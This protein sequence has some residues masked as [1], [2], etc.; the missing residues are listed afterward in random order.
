MLAS[1][2]LYCYTFISTRWS[3]IDEKL[4][5]Q[6]SSV[7]GRQRLNA[8]NN[9]INNIQL[10]LQSIRHAFRSRYGLFGYCLDYK[11]INLLTP[12]SSQT[13]N[14]NDSKQSSTLFCTRCEQ[15]TRQ[16]PDTGCC[17]SYNNLLIF[18]QNMFLFF[19]R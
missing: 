14:E 7:K 2:G 15:T 6:Y 12:K 19:Y 4:I 11:W 3:H 10:Q 18:F 13:T 8:N 1:I 16:C 9:N 5:H 17:V